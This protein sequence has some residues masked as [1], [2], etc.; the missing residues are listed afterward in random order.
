[1]SSSY[2][3]QLPVQ[4]LLKFTLGAT[5]PNS[6]YAQ[7]RAS[8]THARKRSGGAARRPGFDRIGSISHLLAMCGRFTYKLTWRLRY[9]GRLRQARYRNRKP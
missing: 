7:S 3:A 1:M 9:A 4:A 2:S 5:T 8:N 6:S